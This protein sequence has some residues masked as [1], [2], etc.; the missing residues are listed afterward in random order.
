MFSLIL[1]WA[2]LPAAL[3]AIWA[4]APGDSTAPSQ[5]KQT[6]PAPMVTG[7]YQAHLTGAR[8]AALRGTVDLGTTVGDE[9][10][11]AFVITLGASSEDGAIV[12]TQATGT[13]PGPG[14][15]PITEQLARDGVRALVVTGSPT[16]PTGVFRARQG[17]LTI[18][19]SSRYGMA[20]QFDLQ[21]EGFL[22][23]DQDLEDRELTARGSFTA[24]HSP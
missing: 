3:G 18:T 13:Q 7:S 2:T 22:A 19:T 23:T 12:F 21:A 1:R 8:T 14:T 20:G 11:T 9:R 15:Y 17:T 4:L 5:A 16:R 10:G 6:L 24:A